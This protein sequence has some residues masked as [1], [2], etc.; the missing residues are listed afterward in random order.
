MLSLAN[1]HDEA[2]ATGVGD[3]LSRNAR[4]RRFVGM[5]HH[6]DETRAGA[7]VCRCRGKKTRETTAGGTNTHMAEIV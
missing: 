5:C 2:D 1:N 4:T 7:T 3:L 6:S